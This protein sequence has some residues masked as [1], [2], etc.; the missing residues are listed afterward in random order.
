M[1]LTQPVLT[2]GEPPAVRRRGRPRDASADARILAA[3]TELILERGFEATTVDEVALRAKVGKAT[4][5][6]RWARKEDLAVA[7][8]ESLYAQTMEQPDTGSLRGDLS[9]LY[10]GV[11][12]FAGSPS[13]STYL[14]TTIAE[15]IRD[16]RIA[17]LY[18]AAQDRAS[19]Q[20]YAVFMRA[21]QRGEI[22]PGGNHKWAVEW[23]G[24]LLAA[25]TITGAPLPG[26]GDID[27]LVEFV[28]HGVGA[29]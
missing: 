3:A 26:E 2:P 8:M 11:V 24:G 15:C 25:A 17:D 23:I 6:R 29:A 27:S 22:P 1:S 7:A 19:E 9:A 12:A 20:T 21:E 16:R 28:L 10:A 5:Y 4:V 14:R 18:R 13:G